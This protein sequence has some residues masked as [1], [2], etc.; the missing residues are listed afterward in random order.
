[1]LGLHQSC[2]HVVRSWTNQ[3]FG[4]HLHNM[5]LTNGKLR[6]PQDGRYYLY[7]QVSAVF[8]R[9]FSLFPDVRTNE[10]PDPPVPSFRCTFV[11]RPQR[12]A[13]E[14]SAASVTS[15]FSASTRRPPTRVPYRY[16]E[17][18]TYHDGGEVEPA[19]L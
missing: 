16:V 10:P 15:W 6:V 14:T 3:S 1:M 17:S 8:P 7:S 9:V 4:A 11:T 5:T 19:S 2:R 13:T 18:H 12:R